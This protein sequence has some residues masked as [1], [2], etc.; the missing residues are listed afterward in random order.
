MKVKSS[1]WS[2]GHRPRRPAGVHVQALLRVVGG[3]VSP[4]VDQAQALGLH[5]VLQDILLADDLQLIGKD[6][7]DRGLA[8][9]V[10]SR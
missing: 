5:E 7:E 1:S 10:A 3:L 4:Q 8:G 6:A 2:N 9:L